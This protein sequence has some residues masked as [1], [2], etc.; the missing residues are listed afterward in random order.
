MNRISLMIAAA[1][2]LL[3]ACLVVF[4][5]GSSP[6]SGSTAPAASESQAR[7][8]RNPSAPSDGSERP[9]TIAEKIS[10]PQA[11]SSDAEEKPDSPSADD[12][13]S[14]DDLRRVSEMRQALRRAG[15]EYDESTGNVTV[16]H[17]AV[18][19]DPTDDPSL[20]DGHHSGIRQIAEEFEKKIADSGLDP[21]SPEYRRVWNDA[22]RESNW[23]FRARYGARAWA[24]QHVRSF[25][26]ANSP[27]G[28]N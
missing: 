15:E 10:R 7:S 26:L 17:P 6:N 2:I 27:T 16:L 25:H 3:A 20:P 14:K 19:M 1:L 8:F 24:R 5:S 21:G 4:T 22:V 13:P 28:Q 11:T 9:A 12:L 18:F 23:K